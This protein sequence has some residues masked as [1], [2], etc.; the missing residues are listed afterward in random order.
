MSVARPSFLED[1]AN[2]QSIHPLATFTRASTAWIEDV[3]GLWREVAANVPRFG[4]NPVTGQWLGLLI[5]GART[6]SIRNSRLEGA[7]AGTPGTLPNNTSIAASGGLTTNVTATGTTNGIPWVEFQAVGTANA[8]QHV[9][10]LESTTQIVATPGQLWGV[11]LFYQAVSGTNAG[12][13]H[14]TTS[15]TA[16]GAAVS[17][18]TAA[19]SATNTL[20]RHEVVETLDAGGTVARMTTGICHALVNGVTY[21]FRFRIGCPQAEAG[22]SATSPILAPVGAPAATTRAGEGYSVP[23]SA[24]GTAANFDCIVIWEGTVTQV[25]PAG[26]S[27]TLWQVDEGVG[28][29]RYFLRNNGGTLGASLYRTTGGVSNGGGGVSIGTYTED[30]PFRTA[31]SIDGA[32]NARGSLEG[33]AVAGATGGPTSGLTTFR[34]GTRT[35]L[36]DPLNGYCA[37]Y[38]IIPKFADDAT[39]MLLAA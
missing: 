23:V 31:V 1:F 10:V 11:S 3:T 34:I 21:D 32:G 17:T 36:A 29:E 18:T 35:S 33:G 16:A 27:Q 19:I 37:R 15:R 12:V 6:N 22:R 9:I 2:S 38:A 5:E 24:F 30:V 26:V 25:A 20:K 39:T 13:T 8:T 14:N 7:V 4:F 28:N